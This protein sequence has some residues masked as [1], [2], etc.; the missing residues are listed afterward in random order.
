MFGGTTTCVCFPLVLVGSGLLKFVGGGVFLFN[1]TLAFE[2][3]GVAFFRIELFWAPPFPGALPP[4]CWPE[5]QKE[6]A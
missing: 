2:E 3:S 6:Y 1:G 5:F 4:D